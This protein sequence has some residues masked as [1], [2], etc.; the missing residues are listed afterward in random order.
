MVE[1]AQE[2]FKDVIEYLNTLP[3]L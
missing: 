2:L 3:Y 1:I